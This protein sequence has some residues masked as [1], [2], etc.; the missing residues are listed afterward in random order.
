MLVN[1]DP[2]RV[3]VF[4]RT[5]PEGPWA[6]AEHGE[7]DAVPLEALGIALPVGALYLDP[8]A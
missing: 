8:T 5:S 4:A 1:Q 6:F 7:S 2:R 3:E